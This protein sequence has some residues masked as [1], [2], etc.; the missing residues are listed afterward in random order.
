MSS[1]QETASKANSMLLLFD[2]L[3]AIA[4]LSL[5]VDK[6]IDLRKDGKSQSRKR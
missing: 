4:P 1:I 6:S 3:L 5:K 2:C